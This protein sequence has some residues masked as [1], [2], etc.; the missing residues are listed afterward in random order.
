[1]LYKYTLVLKMV[2]VI[3]PLISFATYCDGNEQIIDIELVMNLLDSNEFDKA[4]VEIEKAFKIEPRCDFCY[5][6]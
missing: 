5:F 2:V 3:I 4:S 1:M 6:A